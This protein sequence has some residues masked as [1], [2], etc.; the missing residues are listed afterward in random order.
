LATGKLVGEGFDYPPL[1]TLVLAMP[2]SGAQ[3]RAATRIEGDRRGLEMAQ[4]AD[5][6]QNAGLIPHLLGLSGAQRQTPRY[7][8]YER[9][10]DHFQLALKEAE[11][12]ASAKARQ[13][14]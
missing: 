13:L 9:A 14:V 6:N 5:G 1:D 10:L 4:L 12:E 3:S 11:R 7:K 2:I 8:V